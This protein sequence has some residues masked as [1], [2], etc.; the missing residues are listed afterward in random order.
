MPL[1]SICGKRRRIAALSSNSVGS[2]SR[3]WTCIVC[4][5]NGSTCGKK[6]RTP[7]WWK[8]GSPA[9]AESARQSTSESSAIRV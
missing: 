3:R 7:V 5:R 6:N 9:R 4:S 8:I 1:K 2:P